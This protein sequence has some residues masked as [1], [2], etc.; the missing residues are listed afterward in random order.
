MEI[1]KDVKD[2]EGLYKVSNLGKVKRL[3]GVQCKKER[4]LKVID[5]GSGYLGVSLCKNSI[6]TRK[7]LHRIV[8]DSFLTNDQEKEEVNHIDGIRSNNK[9][10]N[11]EWVTRS[12]NHKHRYDVLGQRGVNY[13]KTG[14][15]NWRSKKVY[16]YT[17]SGDL[18]CHYSA[19]LEAMRQTGINEASIR[20]CIYGRQKSAGGFKWKYEKI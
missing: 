9:L 7:Y 8:A 10:S 17:L 15:K 4:T 12:E 2:Y 20:G 13:G 14:E 11:L 3:I 16:K 19:V 1:W 18:I 6:V 5:N